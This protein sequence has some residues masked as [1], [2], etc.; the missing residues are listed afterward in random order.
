MGLIFVFLIKASLG[1]DEAQR[2]AQENSTLQQQLAATEAE[3]AD[4]FAQVSALQSAQQELND[5]KEL[6]EAELAAAKEAAASGGESSKKVEELTALVDST[7]RE[8]AAAKDEAT[9]STQEGDRL[10]AELDG[11]VQELDD[12]KV[13]K[14]TTFLILKFFF[15]FLLLCFYR[16]VLQAWKLELIRQLFFLRRTPSCASSLLKRTCR[17]ANCRLN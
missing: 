8:L 12:L 1:G 7:R 9:L 5:E 3:R 16:L 17:K 4:F 14:N 6:L 13:A 11:A 10:R 15:F 2:L